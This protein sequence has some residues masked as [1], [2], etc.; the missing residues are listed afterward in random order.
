MR[1]VEFGVSLYASESRA[2][3]HHV[4]FSVD[5]VMNYLAV[6][7]LALFKRNSRYITQAKNTFLRDYYNENVRDMYSHMLEKKIKPN[8]V[9]FTFTLDTVAKTKVLRDSIRRDLSESSNEPN[10]LLDSE[11]FLAEADQD[12]S[13]A[14]NRMPILEAIKDH[15]YN[16]LTTPDINRETNRNQPT[17]SILQTQNELERY[18][19]N[20]HSQ[21]TSTNTED[22]ELLGHGYR[23]LKQSRNEYSR[24]KPY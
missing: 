5:E 14:S 3:S 6:N 13:S 2:F 12:D 16:R 18:L 11:D 17:T 24:R 9:V 10:D 22:Q 4:L 15:Y 1:V 23:L 21:T 7:Y 8:C 19:D 20:L